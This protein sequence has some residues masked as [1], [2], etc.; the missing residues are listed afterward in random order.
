MQ[1][2]KISEIFRSF[3]GEHNRFGIGAPSI[4]IRFYGC[5][6]DCSYCDTRQVSFKEYTVDEVFKDIG[7]LK[8]NTVKKL[9]ITGGEPLEQ[10]KFFLE[11]T[12]FL[13]SQRYSMTVETNGK[14]PRTPYDPNISFVMDWKMPSSGCYDENDLTNI[15]TLED[16]DSVKFV[17][18]DQKDFETAVHCAGYLLNHEFTAEQIVFSPTYSADHNKAKILSNQM[19]SHN[20]PYRISYQ[21][22][23]IIH[24]K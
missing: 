16:E 7:R 23:K 15:L 4:F 21:M 19:I 3:D 13:S 14:H 1:S 2:G 12:D 11:L 20:L 18:D 22:H 5:S 8:A 9:T 17:I 6:C 10:P 24:I